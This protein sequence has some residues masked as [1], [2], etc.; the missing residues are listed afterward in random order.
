MKTLLTQLPPFQS[1]IDKYPET[2]IILVENLR[3]SICQ[4]RLLASNQFLEFSTELARGWAVLEWPGPKLVDRWNQI[5]TQLS[6]PADFHLS[7]QGAIPNDLLQQSLFRFP[8]F[9][10]SSAVAGSAGSGQ[11]EDGV[12]NV[13]R[14]FEGL[15]TLEAIARELGTVRELV[16]RRREILELIEKIQDLEGKMQGAEKADKDRLFS[17]NGA[18]VLQEEEKF[19]KAFKS[20]YPE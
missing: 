9:E 15:K 14:L 17:R 8:L 13:Q 6:N 2:S 5:L 11:R 19:R 16:E 7:A 20:Q 10:S 1:H 4:L 3:E 12:I 18:R